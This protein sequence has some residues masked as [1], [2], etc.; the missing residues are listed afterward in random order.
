MSST[1]WVKLH[2]QILSSSVF[3]D[4]E[5]LR[6]FVWLLCRASHSDQHV[7]LQTGRGTTISKL[8]PGQ[9][10]VGRNASAESLGWKPSNFR[11]R[12]KKLQEIGVIEVHSDNHFSVV[13]I[14]NWLLY[15]SLEDTERTGKGQAKDNQR[16]GKGQAKDT[17]KNEKNSKNDKNEK[18]DSYVDKSTVTDLGLAKWIDHWNQWHSMGLVAASVRP[19]ASDALRKAWKRV[20]ESK[21]VQEL[22]RDPDAI[23]GALKKSEFC[24]DGWFRLEKLLGGKNGDGVFIVEKLLDGGYQSAPATSKKSVNVGPGVK[25]QEGKSNGKF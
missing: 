10:I 8:S 22:L 1:G 23:L 25:Y 19:Q 13:S 9:V 14:V 7:P 11:N 5:L 3:V 16:T 21:E 17:Y 15:Q 18:N 4:A 12:L 2:R 24:R 20:S 6:L